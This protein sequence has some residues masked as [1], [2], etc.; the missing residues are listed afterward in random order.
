MCFIYFFVVVLVA[1]ANMEIK[2]VRS[3]HTQNISIRRIHRFGKRLS[4]QRKKNTHFL[5]CSPNGQNAKSKA[6]TSME[7]FNSNQN[8]F[9]E[10]VASETSID[11]G[12]TDE[13][14]KKFR[15]QFE[16][17]HWTYHGPT[18]NDNSAVRVWTSYYE[19]ETNKIKKPTKNKKT[20]WTEL[21][22]SKY[23]SIHTHTCKAHHLNQ[24]RW[25]N[26]YPTQNWKFLVNVV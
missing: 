17:F 25:K 22:I 23:V 14:K 20:I 4:S 1:D 11:I 13:W 15:F 18:S 7:K 16:C 19:D 24:H 6:S 21:S 2:C 12:N 10:Y 8:I 26:Y 9:I 5:I 3:T